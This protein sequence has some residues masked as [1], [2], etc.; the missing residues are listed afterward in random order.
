[1]EAD[2]IENA[3]SLFRGESSITLLPGLE[4]AESG[5]RLERYDV[6]VIVDGLALRG[7]PVVY[8]S[9]PTYQNLVGEIENI[10][11][12]G[13]LST[14]F[15]MIRGGALHAANGG[16]LILDA[17]RLLSQP[18]AWEALKHALFE[19][20]VRIESLAQRLSLISTRTLEPQPIP[21]ELRV[22]LIG[23]RRIYH[24][25]C[26]LDIE[27]AELF[28][29]AADFDE[30]M[31][32]TAENLPLY[33]RLIAG[34]VR[35]EHLRP[36]DASALARLVEHGSRLAGDS[37]KLSI[38]LRSI[39]DALREADHFAAL[40][41]SD[42]VRA[43]EVQRAL[44]EQ[45]TRLG[46]LHAR[47]LEA[48]RHRTL[49][50]DCEGEV[51]GQVNGLSVTQV[52]AALFGHPARITATVRIG[53]GEV[54]DIEREVR[55]GGAIH[56]KGVLILAALVGARFGGTQPLSLHASIVFEQSYAGVEGDSASLAEGCALVSAIAQVPLRQSF[57]VTGS[58]NQ[59]G[60]VQVIGAVNEKIEGFFDACRL[61]G[62]TGKQGVL[63]PADNIPHLML[64]E[65]V[66][67]AVERGS[68]HIY[69]VHSLEEAIPLLTGLQ[70][71]AR[72]ANGAY[73]P[74]TLHALV[75]QRLREFAR[76][77]QQ[78]AHDASATRRTGG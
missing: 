58:I 12:F 41:G 17:E 25:L 16:F 73:T 68:F 44:D 7:A 43:A 24:L 40:A 14:D 76:V 37:R 18:F 57:A 4:K 75:E 5:A 28:K 34:S 66:I 31:D 1:M 63:I 71:G 33:A 48:I 47:I 59:H 65:D 21:L 23:T 67:D 50:I 54:L 36:F 62:L 9:N 8:E 78:F 13:M 30:M 2:L 20:R 3:G 55:L 19:R 46:R 42:V 26:E 74:G 27:F 72:D 45:I 15:T 39:E 10:A 22:M 56:S 53:E 64:R 70:A 38:H 77:R 11:Q 61:R 35:R 49:L 32:R 69:G 6:N 60:M 29:V 51:I 52:G